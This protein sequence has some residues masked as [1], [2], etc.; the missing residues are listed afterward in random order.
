M[1]FYWEHLGM[2]DNPGYRARWEQKR[3]E[4][5]ECGIGPSEDGGGPEGILIETSDEPGGSLD[6]TAIASAIDGVI[7]G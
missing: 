2:L 6:A 1:T 7:L 4:Y 3:A 5:L